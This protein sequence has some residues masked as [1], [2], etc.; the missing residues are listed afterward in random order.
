MSA[1]PRRATPWW[2]TPQQTEAALE[3]LAVTP[4]PICW[5]PL[6]WLS[7][8]CLVAA[9]ALQRWGGGELMVAQLPQPEGDPYIEH[10]MVRVGEDRYLDAAGVHGG[11]EILA[12]MQATSGDG[13][14]TAGRWML[15]PCSAAVARWQIYDNRREVERL[16]MRLERLAMPPH[17]LAV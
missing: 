5:V 14:W 6:T 3:L 1:R 10:V 16:S 15:V 2:P 4:A 9:R 8:G 13:V 7:G 17:G 11:P 12:L